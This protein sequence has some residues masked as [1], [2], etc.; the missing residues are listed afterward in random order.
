MSAPAVAPVTPLRFRIGERT[1]WTA[2]RRLHRVGLDLD[3]LLA[4]SVP[5]LPDLA[6]AEGY[7]LRSWPADAVAEVARPGLLTLVRHRY[8]RRFVRL[9]DWDAYWQ[10]FSGKTRA[11]LKR[12]RSRWEKA[13]GGLDL[14][15]YHR[16]D[17]ID[18]F[19][20]LAGALSKLTYQDRLLGAGLPTGPAALAEMRAR[21]ATGRLRAFILFDRGRPAS[22]LYLPV[23]GG[24]AVYA[25]LGYD[26]ALADLSPGTGLHLAV[27]D[28]LFAD[29]ALG[30][31][32]FTEGD[33]AHKRL[34]G[35]EEVACVDLLLLRRTLRNRALTTALGGFDHG[36]AAGRDWSERAGVKPALRRLL[37]R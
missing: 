2:R 18:A 5:A 12:K 36:V 19:H 6:A 14:R 7:D 34:F 27:F 30:L 1:L 22:Y 35:R 25:H 8:A 15:D 32:D 11:T 10:G 28:R 26:P 17:Q 9:E 20:E 24:T 33:G 29:P 37:R 3:Q 13:A 21:A 31:L 4:G 16:P 23:E